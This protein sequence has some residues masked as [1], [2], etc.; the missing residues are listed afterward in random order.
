MA[1]KCDQI[2]KEN[3]DVAVNDLTRK[4]A[5]IHNENQFTDSS[6]T[7]RQIVTGFVSGL[8]GGFTGVLVSDLVGVVWDRINPNSD[9]NRLGRTEEMVR[10]LMHREKHILNAFANA[11]T[12]ISKSLSILYCK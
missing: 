3:W 4:C 6:Q 11:T 2:F 8:A 1:E 9:H 12:A 10:N 5:P 7:K